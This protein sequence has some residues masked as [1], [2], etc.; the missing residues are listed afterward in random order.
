MVERGL[1]RKRVVF[2]G[3]T[4][5]VKYLYKNGSESCKGERLEVVVFAVRAIEDGW[6]ESTPNYEAGPPYCT[7]L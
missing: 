4:D 1:T 6:N 2:E 5:P 7:L 3:K